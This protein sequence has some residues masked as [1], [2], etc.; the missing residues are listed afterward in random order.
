M[1]NLLFSQTDLANEK[2]ERNYYKLQHLQKK[3]ILIV[4]FC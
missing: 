2:Q 3:K 4:R 1:T